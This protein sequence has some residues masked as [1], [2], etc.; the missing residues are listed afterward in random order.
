MDAL[1]KYADIIDMPHHRSASRNHMTMKERAMQFAP[2]AALRGY[3][4]E[5]EASNYAVDNSAYRDDLFGE[6][7]FEHS[8]NFG[9]GDFYDGNS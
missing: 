5:I 3:D 6:D 4:E 8:L 9:N 2:F 7:G 1:K